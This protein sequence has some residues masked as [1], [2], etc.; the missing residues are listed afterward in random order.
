MAD[1]D[2]DLAVVLEI[3]LEPHARLEVEVVGG[4][5]EQEHGRPHEQGLGQ[6]DPHAPAAAELACL[7][8]LHLGREP[9]A[10]EQLAGLCRRL[11]HV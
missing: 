6:R 8:L 4:L 9:E 3:V 11:L 2:E 10:V 5:V 7:L 1:D